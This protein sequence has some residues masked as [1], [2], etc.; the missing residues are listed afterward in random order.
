MDSLTLR[1][2]GKSGAALTL[3]LLME[4][5][6]GLLGYGDA[7]AAMLAATLDAG[8]SRPNTAHEALAAVRAAAS[9]R[10]D[11]IDTDR[12]LLMATLGED[13]TR[14]SSCQIPQAEPP[15][16]Q[17]LPMPVQSLAWPRLRDLAHAAPTR[18]SRSNG[19][20]TLGSDA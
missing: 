1:H 6:A 12:A 3:R 7:E 5:F 4:R 10:Y 11:A 19:R 2:D 16:A 17:G 9:D 13:P 15:L 20:A 8:P 18:R 14:V